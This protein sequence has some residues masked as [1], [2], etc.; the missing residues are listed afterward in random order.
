MIKST[1]VSDLN[2]LAT[3]AAFS[4]FQIANGIFF[5]H[6][7]SFP[8]SA[9]GS[10]ACFKPNTKD[11]SN[12]GSNPRPLNEIHGTL[13]YVSV[14]PQP[15]PHLLCSISLLSQPSP[16]KPSLRICCH[17]N[18][19]EPAKK[20]LRVLDTPHCLTDSICQTVPVSYKQFRNKTIYR[21]ITPTSRVYKSKTCPSFHHL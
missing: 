11:L 5:I 20:R 6:F 10:P 8:E 9:R 3:G 19:Q 12:Q 4:M 13:T 17:S 1:E 14:Q 2:H 7:P 21:A 18:V 15:H 16:F